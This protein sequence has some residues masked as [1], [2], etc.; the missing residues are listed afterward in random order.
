[1]VRTVGGGGGAPAVR[2]VDSNQW[3]HEH[4]RI[5]SA[6][7][8]PSSRSASNR[9]AAPITTGRH[10][11]WQS[12]TPHQR[13][14]RVAG[15]GT[16]I[17]EPQSRRQLQQHR[18]AARRGAVASSSSSSSSRGGSSPGSSDSD[19]ERRQLEE[20]APEFI[21]APNG[22]PVLVKVKAMGRWLLHRP[23]L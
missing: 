23:L 22:E 11:R 7:V 10:V 5:E 12:K 1:M 14:D 17:L 8:P 19:S 4:N 18:R 9:L 15:A 6:I 16:G 20:E 2:Q 3:S 13:V 21:R